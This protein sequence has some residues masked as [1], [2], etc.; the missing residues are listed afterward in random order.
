MACTKIT[1]SGFV[2][3]VGFRYFVRASAG[4]LGLKGY[5]R[6]LPSGKVEVICSGDSLSIN[7][8]ISLCKKGPSMSDIKDVRVE[9]IECSER[10]KSFEVRD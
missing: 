2:H 7:K 5:V 6:N 10:Y 8:L 1:I 4:S 3:G 9:E